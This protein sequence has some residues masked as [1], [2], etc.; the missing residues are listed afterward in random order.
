MRFLSVAVALILAAGSAAGAQLYRWVDEKGRVE[1]RDTPPPPEAKNV[2]QRNMG[3]NTI[4]TSTLPY[5]LQVAVK[6]HPVTLWVFDCGD[7]C[8]T[9]RKH[10]VRRGIPHTERSPTKEGEALKK[11]TGGLEVPVLTVGSTVSK[12][13]LE[14]DWDAA[15]D[16]AGYP[17]TPAPGV[18][19][20]IQAAQKSEA[21]KSGAKAEPGAAKAPTPA[22]KADAAAA[23]APPQPPAKAETPKTSARQP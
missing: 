21:Q 4:Q 10:L 16:S 8:T 11:L 2:E 18:Q 7:P 19:A 20:Q 5:S 9:A 1:W 3:G 6:K 15:L 13:Y 14:S 23:K 22:S 12:G 17:R